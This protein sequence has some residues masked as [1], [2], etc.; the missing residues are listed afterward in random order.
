MQT[1]RRFAFVGAYIALLTFP[2]SQPAP[3]FL[4]LSGEQYTLLTRIVKWILLLCLVYEINSILNTWA[5]NRWV[6]TTDNSSWH[7]TKELAVVTGGSNG[8]GAAVVKELVKHGVKVAVL[9][10]QPLS[11]AVDESNL[12]TFYQCDLTSRDAVHK[13]AEALRSDHGSPSVLINNAGIGNSSSILDLSPKLLQTC[14]SLNLISHWYTVQEFLPDMIANK[15]GHIM[16]T[17]SIAAFLGM[18]NSGDYAATK[19]GLVAFHETLTQELKHRYNC[20]QV[21]TSIVYPI[22]TSTRLTI[23]LDDSFRKTFKDPKDVAKIMV[24]QIIAAKSGQLVLGPKLAP[25]VRMFPMWLQEIVRDSQAHIVTGNA[26][27]AVGVGS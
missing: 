13:A 21:K 7:W 10:I 6:F 17:S 8:I 23:S 4:P 2:S 18:A 1:T 26:T 11:E 3:A 24:N 16:A 20:P 14:V 9:D 12:V 19:A 22:W 15:K 25:Y 27:S 5:E